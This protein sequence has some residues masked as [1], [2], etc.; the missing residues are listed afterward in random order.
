MLASSRLPVRGRRL[1]SISCNR[2]EHQPIALESG[3][4]TAQ[5][6]RLSRER[7]RRAGRCCGHERGLIADY[8][9]QSRRISVV[10]PIFGPSQQELS[11]YLKYMARASHPSHAVRSPWASGPAT[12]TGP[13]HMAAPTARATPAAPEFAVSTGCRVLFRRD[14]K[15]I[16]RLRKDRALFV[17]R[18]GELPWPT[19][20]GNLGSHDK[21]VVDEW[22]GVHH[23]P[24]IRGDALA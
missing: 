2:P 12:N 5:G 3:L 19:R 21:A 9:I 18:L 24:D 17:D 23:G 8:S 7:A 4:E 20:V 11:R 13:L 22:I 15:V 14:A 16:R 10:R 1:S 6:G